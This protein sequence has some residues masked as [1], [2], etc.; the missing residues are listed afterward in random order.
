M[1]HHDG[2]CDNISS[3]SHHQLSGIYEVPQK[4]PAALSAASGPP[5]SP[6][7]LDGPPLC[8]PRAS[9]TPH[10][11][12]DGHHTPSAHPSP[13]ERSHHSGPSN[14]DLSDAIFGASDEEL[15]SLS[16]TESDFCAIQPSAESVPPRRVGC[17]SDSSKHGAR[18]QRHR[19]SHTSARSTPASHLSPTQDSAP[20]QKLAPMVK[21]LRV[22]DSQDTT[23][24]KSLDADDRGAAASVK[25]KKVLPVSE[26]EIEAASCVPSVV[27]RSSSP[28]SNPVLEKRVSRAKRDCTVTT[29][30]VD[31]TS[32]ERPRRACIPTIPSMVRTNIEPKSQLSVAPGQSKSKGKG[33][34]GPIGGKPRPSILSFWD[35][36]VSSD[37][38][39][40]TSSTRKVDEGRGVVRAAGRPRKRPILEGGMT[41]THS[42]DGL[43][44]KRARVGLENISSPCVKPSRSKKGMSMI[45]ARKPAPPRVLKTYRNRPKTERSSPGLSLNCDVD[46]DEIPPLTIVLDSSTAKECTPPASTTGD[47]TLAPSIL[48]GRNRHGLT[49]LPS[50]PAAGPRPADETADDKRVNKAKPKRGHARLIQAP[51]PKAMLEDDDP[52][53]SFSSSPCEPCSLGDTAVKVFEIFSIAWHVAFTLCSLDPMPQLP[54]RLLLF[55]KP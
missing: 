48:Q 21:G 41:A 1:V 32:T 13:S 37:E 20:Q 7:R 11:R 52:I 38:S 17:D 51:S 6:C 9:S 49:T 19:H 22:M 46:Y 50:P 53:Q 3:T 44:H 4:C 12:C 28:A 24:D 40:M 2:G 33:K 5:P 26:D 34:K 35:L 42:E 27:K 47:P 8:S 10:S 43:P 29:A 14:K 31:G 39:R 55:P 45:K 36:N 15:S 23:R 54:L 25:R 18:S 30:Q 16:D